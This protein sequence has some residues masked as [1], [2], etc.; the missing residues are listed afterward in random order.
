MR[1]SIEMRE[2][3]WF[4]TQLVFPGAT[5]A[6][7][8]VPEPHTYLAAG[9]AVAAAAIM[10]A[11][12]AFVHTPI[13]SF[14]VVAECVAFAW[15]IPSIRML[16]LWAHETSFGELAQVMD[17]SF[18]GV[19]PL[20]IFFALARQ[21]SPLPLVIVLGAAL[22]AVAGLINSRVSPFRFTAIRVI[23]V[24]VLM[25]APMLVL[26]AVTGTSDFRRIMPAMLLLYAG[27]TGVALS[28]EGV[29]P[30]IRTA[31]VLL[32][33]VAQVATASANGLAFHTPA[34]VK[35]QQFLGP[36][37]WPATGRDPNVPVLDG[38]VG[39]GISS[40]NI[41]A[42]TY[43]YRDYNTCTQRNI[44]PFEPS[45][46]GT[47]ARERHL[48]IGVHFAGDLDF[49]KPET[50]AAQIRTRDFQYVLVDMFDSPAVVNT[51][52]SYTR[53]T[54]RFIALERGTLPHGLTRLGCF[55]TANRP[56]CVL[57]IERP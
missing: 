3:A 25:L 39:L 21:Y 41:A 1:R 17:Q 40:G 48:P 52:D 42:Y 20:A 54:E 28:P 16:Y 13:L 19:S 12:R 11:R 6:A 35:V 23:A 55:S 38:I 53:H 43:C 9:C 29:L 24:A 50:L 44:P 8:A 49:S 4:F 27:L 57:R 5:I 14:F 32:L 26:Y 37:R 18:R 22:L 30:R 56:I 2:L 36:L 46:L 31:V 7:L 34:L 47:L 10:F 51:A 15:N 45:A 33:M